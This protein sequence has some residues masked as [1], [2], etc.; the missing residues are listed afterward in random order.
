MP[1]SFDYSDGA[2]VERR[3]VEL[4]QAADQL[5][6]EVQIAAEEQGR[7][8]PLRYHL[9]AERSQLL[10]HFDFSGLDVLELGAGMGAVSRLLAE[11]AASLTVVE[12]SAERFA[13][14]SAR[15]RDLDNWSGEVV[16]ME[17]FA[18]DRHFDVVLMIGVLEYAELYV[19]MPA[20]AAVDDPAGDAF[21]FILRRARGYLRP[22]GVLLLAIENRLG[23][24]YWCGAAED[25]SGCLFDGLA[26]YPAA[27]VT[28]TFGRH[29]LAARL[30]RAGL[31]HRQEYLPFPDYKLTRSIL[32]PDLARRAP[33]LAADLACYETSETG[34]QA[35]SQL[36]PDELVLEGLAR[37]GLL[38][39]HANSFLIAA[40]GLE[41]SDILRHLT[42]EPEDLAKAGCQTL[43]W[44]YSRD[45]RWPTVSRLLLDPRGKLLADKQAAAPPPPDLRRLADGSRIRW[46]SPG[47]V[48]VARGKR[49][50]LELLRELYF[51]RWQAFVDRLTGFCNWVADHLP[52]T[53]AGLDGRALD[54]VLTNAVVVERGPST[55]ELFDLEWQLEDIDMRRSWHVLRNVVVLGGCWHYFHRRLEMRCLGELYDLLCGRLGL[56]ADLAADL[57]LE[58]SFQRLVGT[59]SEEQAT[60]RFEKLLLEPFSERRPWPRQPGFE[61]AAESELQQAE[62]RLRGFKQEA[63]QRIEG[64][65]SRLHQRDEELAQTYARLQGLGDQNLQLVDTLAAVNAKLA[66]TEEELR[67]LTSKEGPR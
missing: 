54:A 30:T 23:V 18:S 7:S 35:R 49:L 27:P 66:A 52:G 37:D 2:A 16:R 43:A 6:S 17:H 10:R 47:L 38:V 62:E 14:L 51:D 42:A 4:I 8:W 21:D 33:R 36:L 50:R 22:G 44:H 26:G 55:Y 53:S 11:R 40:C 1:K 61:A 56:T 34:G 13:G 9:A 46:R 31:G 63:E 41:D 5:G 45:R 28:R 48:L 24:K 67:Q 65:V 25:H 57:K 64:E 19:E 58:V 15:L 60:A 3:V 12:A 59:D 29:E 32:R 20:E 39:E